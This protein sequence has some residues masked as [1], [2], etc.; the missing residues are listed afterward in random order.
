MQ[1]PR[2]LYLGI[3]GAALGTLPTAAVYFATYE[4]CKAKLEARHCGQAVTHV[5]SASV[6]AILSAFVKVPSDTLKHQVQAYLFPNVWQVG[7]SGMSAGMACTLLHTRHA[8]FDQANGDTKKLQ[9]GSLHDHR[10]QFARQ[11]GCCAACQWLW[12]GKQLICFVV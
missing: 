9:S 4:W 2:D 12:L 6:G 10:T 8:G 11:G 7:T 1:G 3:F 5:T